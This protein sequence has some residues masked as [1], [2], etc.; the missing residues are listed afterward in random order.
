MVDVVAEVLAAPPEDRLGLAVDWLHTLAPAGQSDDVI[1]ARQWAGLWPSS[2]RLLLALCYARGKTRHRENL[3][4]ALDISDEALKWQVCYLRKGLRPMGF[5][6][7]V[8]VVW[9]EGYRIAQDVGAEI[10][11]QIRAVA[12]DDD[13][14]WLATRYAPL[15]GAYDLSNRAKPWTAQ[16]DADLLRMIQAGWDWSAIADEMGRTIRACNERGRRIQ[17]DGNQE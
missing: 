14:G 5:G 17:K 16:E 9:G 2:A 13:S 10:L 12:V 7:A 4:V 3:C 11:R 1:R 15:E 6:D 8:Q